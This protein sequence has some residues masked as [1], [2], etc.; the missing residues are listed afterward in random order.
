MDHVRNLT[1]HLADAEEAWPVDGSADL[2]RDDWV[3]ALR[4][5]QVRRPGAPEAEP[6]RRLVLEHPGA[7]VVLAIDGA[8]RVCCLLQY[9]HPVQQR[10]VELPAGLCDVPGEDPLDV[11]RR[12]LAEE[13]GLAAAS[14]THLATTYSSPGLSTEQMHFYLA[15]DLTHV[16]RDESGLVHEEA[17]MSIVWAPFAELRAAA[18]EGRVADAPL[19]LAVLLAEARGVAADRSIGE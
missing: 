16:G 11:A 1:D 8:D 4:A 6:F 7:A 9:R 15:R 5:D 17:E 2:H 13:V 14:W 10:L 18:L 12:E 3:V 19:V